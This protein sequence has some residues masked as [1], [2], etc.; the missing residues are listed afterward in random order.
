MYTCNMYMWEQHKVYKQGS[1]DKDY[2]YLFRVSLEHY[3]KTVIKVL[4]YV[5]TQFYN[6]HRVGAGR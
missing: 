5:Y 1:V 2:P 4:T 3:H 6:F